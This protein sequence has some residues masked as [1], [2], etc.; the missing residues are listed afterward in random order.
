MWLDQEKVM[1]SYEQRI[2]EYFRQ[3]RQERIVN[4]H[5]K[6]QKPKMINLVK[7]NE[8]GNKKRLT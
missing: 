4:D 2:L 8:K 3:K 5:S 1:I 6:A 7:G